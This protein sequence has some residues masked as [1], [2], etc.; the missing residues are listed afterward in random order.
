MFREVVVGVDF[1]AGGYE[2]VALARRLAAHGGRLT[3]VHVVTDGAFVPARDDEMFVDAEHARTLG[4]LD[5]ERRLLQLSEVLRGDRPPVHVELRS[6]FAGGAARGVWHVASAVAADLIV[7][8]ASRRGRTGRLLGADDTAAIL[9]R[10]SGAVAISV[11]IA[12]AGYSEVAELR[13]LEVAGGDDATENRHLARI[14]GT[15]AA[16]LGAEVVHVPR[17]AAGA[18]ASSR[19]LD[20]LVV[21]LDSGASER[22]WSGRRA[23]RLVRLASCPLLVVVGP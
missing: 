17:A 3:L 16:G 12:P 10:A 23:A 4:L 7:L 6:V 14:A 15:L 9:R 18:A 2:A 22:P 21:G 11:A 20:L 5:R 13:R 19:S 1:G 8:G